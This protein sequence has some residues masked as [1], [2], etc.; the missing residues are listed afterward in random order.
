MGNWTWDVCASVICL[1]VLVAF[2][3][4]LL[5]CTLMKKSKKVPIIGMVC[6]LIFMVGITLTA[7]LPNLLGGGLNPSHPAEQQAS[8]AADANAAPYSAP[9]QMDTASSLPPM[10]YAEKRFKQENSRANEKMQTAES[11]FSQETG[12]SASPDSSAQT[13]S[14]AEEQP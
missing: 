8:N 12:D 6:C 9:Q 1:I 10:A 4:A 7:Q 14:S 13:V 5:A 11:H 2:V 3:I